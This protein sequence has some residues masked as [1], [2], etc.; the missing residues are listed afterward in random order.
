MLM[1]HKSIAEISLLYE[2]WMEEKRN[3]KYYDRIR[4]QTILNTL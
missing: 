2:L 4:L 1:L 3:I